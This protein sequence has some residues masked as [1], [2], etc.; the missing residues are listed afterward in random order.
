MGSHAFAWL[1]TMDVG[2]AKILAKMFAIIGS[3]G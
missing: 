2:F 1:S 3:G